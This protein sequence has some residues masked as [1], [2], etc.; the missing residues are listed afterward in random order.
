MFKNYLKIAIRSLLKNSVYSFI[1][2]S[3]LS[4]GIAS[5]VLILL[6]VA[7]EYSYD[8][9]QKNYDSIYKL[10][11]SQQWAQGIGTGNSMPYPMKE[12]IKDKSS[13]IKHVVM[14]NWGEGNMLQVGEKR[15][16]KLGL[17]ASEDFFKVFTFNM[18][19]GDPNTALSD[20][21]S[22]V[23]TE[24][25][26]KTF[27]DN[28]DPINQ[29]IKVDN[30][31]ELKVTGVVKDVPRQ[32]FFR[33]DYVMPFAY[34]EATQSW[35]R[36]SKD[37]WNNN[38][39]QMYVQLQPGASEAE[40]NKS[41]ENIIK[42]NNPKAPT[43]KLFLHPM[44]KW[45][46]YS[47]FENGINSGGMIEY[48]RL[49]TAIAIFV[50]VIACI[51]FMNLAT[52]RSESRAREVGIRKSVGS[53]RKELI[54]QFLGESVMVTFIS[55]VLAL[56]L[57]ELVLPS[58]NLLVNKNIFIDYSNPWLWSI[59]LGWVLV[60]GIFSGSYPAFYLSSFQPVKVLKGKVNVGKG[61]TTPRKVLVTLQFGFSIFL[62]IGTI[63]IYQQIMH[64]KNR[65]M[66]YDREN[67]MQ[68]WTNGEL[69]TNFQTI[70]EELVRTGV[71][72]SVCKSN[73]PI[74][75]IFSNNEVKWEGMPDQRVGFSTI[76][77]EYDYTETMGIKM[78]EGRDFSRDFKSDSMAVIVNQAAVDLMGMEEP[79]GQKI[80][81]NDQELEIIGVMPNVVM[82]SPYQPVEAMT[83]IFDPDWS[84]TITL[85]LNKTENLAKSITK[86]ETVFK[87][88]NPT[89]PFE[90]RFA[91]A[92]FER[93]FATINLISRLATIFASLAIIIT[94][95]GLFG[96]AA[97]TAEQRTKEVG[98]RKV[99]GASVSSLV[100]LISKDFSRLV[101]FGFLVSGPIAWWF[102]NNF[103][104]RYT[105]RI[106]IMWWILP[107]AGATALVLALIIVSTQ[108][109][110]AATANPSQSL[111]SE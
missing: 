74:T 77:T 11:Q 75:S 25:T 64:V 50:L 16:N 106:S 87:K 108:A 42:D 103:L 44:S 70:R 71:V 111:R 19:K 100:L 105:Y 91:D 20:P 53:R 49:F 93:K 55:S 99:M 38:S 18:V 104:E 17:S 109:L 65:D 27:F 52:A 83:L 15:L 78:I 84:S 63:V 46:L 26:A 30:G 98:I 66:G 54:F 85:R 60:I 96:L 80:I 31:Q 88:L 94:C 8:R 101:I 107:L 6:W 35:V 62:I 28:A 59:A 36:Y 56:V 23:I 76:A 57:V 81:Y 24:S 13:Q 47:N 102:L 21:S 10:Y 89:Y 86:V 22:I 40:V 12:T 58:Y 110:K 5:A 32:S 48:V 43:A 4:I 51:N 90:F 7:D 92:D 95:L 73:S 41:I 67:L 9:F 97:F 33:F 3:G 68:I 1:N 45:R 69:E 14:T 37:N 29:L 72:K 82:D 34:Y 61:A 39:F 79:L 2:I